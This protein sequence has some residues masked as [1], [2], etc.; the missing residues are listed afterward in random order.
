MAISLGEYDPEAKVLDVNLGEFHPLPEDQNYEQF[1]N[2]YLARKDRTIGETVWA[3]AEAIPDGMGQMVDDIDAALNNKNMVD[4]LF[5]L[6]ENEGDAKKAWESLYTASEIGLRDSYNTFNAIT[7]STINHFSDLEGEDEIKA[8]Y[9]VHQYEQDY[10]NIAREKM[11]ESVAP[12]FRDDMSVL[13]DFLDPTNLIPSTFGGKFIEKGVRKGIKG[14]TKV[15][16]VGGG[17]IIQGLGH[18]VEKTFGFPAWI[19]DKAKIKSGW[20]GIQGLGLVSAVG[21]DGLAGG[22]GTFVTGVAAL[23]FAGK[24]AKATGREIAEISRV[25]AQPSSHARFLHRVSVDETVSAA[26]RKLAARLYKMRGTKAYDVLFDGL[27]AGLSSGAIQVALEAA[28]GKSAE[29]VGA[30]TGGGIILGSPAG[31]IA[32]NRGSGKD[33]ASLNQDGTLTERSQTGVDDYLAKK[34]A[35][36][37]RKTIRA[38]KKL[39]AKSKVA[40]STLDALGELG[41]VRLHLASDADFRKLAEEAGD[42][43]ANSLP[44]M[45]QPPTKTIIL[46]EDL[47]EEGVEVAQELFLHE[48]GHAFIH[49]MLGNTPLMSRSILEQFEDPNGTEYFFRDADGKKIGSIKVND[50]AHA[51]SENYAKEIA[52]QSKDTSDKLKQD[53]DAFLLAHEIGAEQ[54]SMIFR[55]EPNA[56][57]SHNKSFR[58]MLIKAGQDALTKMGIL[59]PKTGQKSESI[60]SESM[61]KNK[62]IEKVYNNHIKLKTEHYRNRADDIETGRKIEPKAGQKSDERFQQLFGGIGVNLNLAKQFYIQDPQMYDELMAALEEAAAA[63]GNY[64]GLGKGE[65]ANR[66]F[67]K[68]RDVFAKRGAYSNQV[69]AILDFLQTAIDTRT[70]IKFGYRSA[71]GNKK[72]DY[73][74]FYERSITPIGYQISPKK[75]RNWRGKTIYPNLKVV[76]YDN[77]VIFSNIEILHNAGLLGDKSINKFMNEFA[78]RA[79]EVL[80]ADSEGRINPLGLGENEL[81]VAALGMKES[82]DSIQ[83]PKLKEFL[84]SEETKSLKNAYKSYD[85]TQLAGMQTQNRAGFGFDYRNAANNYMPALAGQGRGEPKAKFVANRDPRLTAKVAEV[86]EGTLLGK[87]YKKFVDKF[88]PV[89]VLTKDDITP[90]TLSEMRK[91]LK[92]NQVPKVNLGKEI[93]YGYPVGVRLDIDAYRYHDVWTPTIHE[94]KSETVVVNGKK[95]RRKKQS[96]IAHDPVAVIENVKFNN[97]FAESKGIGRGEKRKSSFARM[98]GNWVP[99]SVKDAV[100]LAEEALANKDGSWT[101]VGFDPERHSYFYDRE[102]HGVAMQTSDKVVQVGRAVFAKNAVKQKAEVAYGE[103]NFYAPAVKVYG[104]RDNIRSNVLGKITQGKFSPEQF[105]AKVRETKGAKEMFEDLKLDKFLEGKKSITAKEVNDFI[106]LNFPKI[107]HHSSVGGSPIYEDYIKTGGTNNYEEHVTVL[108]DPNFENGFP[109]AHWDDENVMFHWRK[110]DRY[111]DIGNGKIKPLYYLEEIQSDWHQAGRNNGY[112]TDPQVQQKL[113]DFNAYRDLR[114]KKWNEFLESVDETIMPDIENHDIINLARSYAQNNAIELAIKKFRNRLKDGSEMGFGNVLRDLFDVVRVESRESPEVR[115]FISD[116]DGSISVTYQLLKEKIEKKQLDWIGNELEKAGITQKMADD[117]FHWHRDNGQFIVPDAPFKK[118]WHGLA[119]KQAIAH[120]LAE[121]REYIAWGTGDSMA[122]LFKKDQFYDKIEVRKQVN[123]KYNIEAWTK[124]RLTQFRD[125]NAD[126]SHSNLDQKDLAKYIGAEEASLTVDKLKSAK[127]WDSKKSSSGLIDFDRSVPSVEVLDL[128]VKNQGMRNFYD[129]DLPDAA[130]VIAKQLGVRQPIKSKMASPTGKFNHPA[131]VMELP[132]K[133]P[134]V[135]NDLT[136]YMPDVKAG[137]LDQKAPR[138][139]W[140]QMQ[141]RSPKFQNFITRKGKPLFADLDEE[142]NYIPKVMYHGGTIGMQTSNPD[143]YPMGFGTIHNFGTPRDELWTPSDEKG[144]MAFFLSTDPNFSKDYQLGDMPPLQIATNVSNTF[145]FKNEDHVNKLAEKFDGDLTG[146]LGRIRKGDW[147]AI[148]DYVDEIRELGYDSF[149]IKEELNS[150]VNEIAENLGVFSPKDVK[151]IQDQKHWE[152][153]NESDLNRVGTVSG[154]F[155]GSALFA[156]EVLA[157]I[158]V[159][160]LRTQSIPTLDHGQRVGASETFQEFRDN[161]VDIANKVGLEVLE[162]KSVIGGLKDSVTGTISREASQRLFVRSK[163]DKSVN[164]FAAL[165][166]VLADELQDSVMQVRYIKRNTTKNEGRE[167]ALKINPDLAEVVTSL[168]F[169][170]KYGLE[171]GF[172]YDPKNS[173]LIFA[174]WDSKGWSSV[175]AAASAIDELGGLQGADVRP[176]TVSFPQ[177]KDYRRLLSKSRISDARR[178]GS[179]RDIDYLAET[180]RQKLKDYNEAGLFMPAVFGEKTSEKSGMKFPTI[181]YKNKVKKG[182]SLPVSS[183]DWD[184]DQWQSYFEDQKLADALMAQMASNATPEAWRLI[185]E[186]RTARTGS[187]EFPAA[188]T[189]ILSW[190]NDPQ[191]LVQFIEEARTKN[192]KM[193]DLAKDGINAA[194]VNYAATK[195]PEVVAQSFIW[196]FLSRMLDPYNQEAG[197]LRFYSD[198]KIWNALWQSI[199]GKFDMPRGI[200]Y[201]MEKVVDD[202]PSYGQKWKASAAYKKIEAQIEAFKAKKLEVKTKTAKDGLDKKIKAAKKKLKSFIDDRTKKL[203]KKLKDEFLAEAK[204]RNLNQQTGTWIDLISNM[205][206]DQNTENMISAGQNARQNANGA[207]SLLLKWNGKWD[208]VTEI[209]NSDMTGQ[210][211]REQMWSMGLEGGGIG[212]KV[213]SFVIATMADSGVVIMDRWAFVNAWLNEIKD[214]VKMRGNQL[215]SVLEDPNTDAKAKN[216]ASRLLR[217]YEKYGDNPFRYSADDIPEDR[218]N[219]YDTI[220]SKLSPMAEHSMYRTIEYYYQELAN[221][222]QQIDPKK[223]DWIDSPF[224]MHWLLWNIIKNEAVGHSSLEV[225]SD[226]LQD[227]IPQPKTDAE[228]KQYADEFINRPNYAEKNEQLPTEDFERRSRFT[229]KDG[230]P[231]EEVTERRSYRGMGGQQTGANNVYFR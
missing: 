199:D 5:G 182:E 103:G 140:E 63:E 37:D 60:I 191:K 22:I 165:A 231:T 7:Q 202:H 56:F 93:P 42:K 94:N 35:L 117:L 177:V 45:Y 1:K 207:Y 115:A 156:P 98:E 49:N 215:R 41:G 183:K 223:Y 92:E 90:P 147:M 101:Q 66:L 174:T 229:I 68:V 109:N 95:K 155:D 65:E 188:P 220:G 96:S 196:G 132:K 216:K 222:L 29:E 19:A 99:F 104:L 76:G 118:S 141:Y 133:S 136:L 26:S 106:E 61:L 67:S 113:R 39:D 212:D 102:N 214:S 70:Q 122:D 84:Q 225:L 134:D 9:A 230:R 138:L 53:K 100:T 31:A 91:A 87:D 48:F 78:Q 72:S 16:G 161:N 143:L 119:L 209:F 57:A 47:L 112:D 219:F 211:M 114:A 52:S 108:N 151:L 21:A 30:A 15:L 25:F 55:D 111:V 189:V 142:G 14:G 205:Y 80:S 24:L 43:L 181:T 59:D 206:D 73:N 204:D 201:T 23:E 69:G 110:S 10:F 38:F 170:E 77:D 128:E 44:A 2:A 121:G 32:G 74:A 123:G 184:N 58:H 153:K 135:L 171:E 175:A 51:F 64:V 218:S 12:E 160:R 145:D 194:K 163:D 105:L 75:I 116:S 62:G 227:N 217:E 158:G 124:N 50:E 213:T 169:L 120:A 97:H 46:N 36:L 107:E 167:Y 125:S 8:A 82:Y 89:D 226:V 85:V 185:N 192:P 40:L 180:A 33:T 131:W 17:K 197:W 4:S 27:V 154:K 166:G 152:G 83:E 150:N 159:A 20:R 190:L 173:E 88:K 187:A 18:T 195:T 86:T 34:A 13:A 198:P 139:I 127:P 54:F 210:Q 208:K 71:T 79:Q 176:A 28:K 221:K 179:K 157:N 172:T 224:A 149:L 6:G 130:K 148:E 81:M 178:R 168:Q 164:T 137:K 193:I 11:M 144:Q 200:Y 186:V 228:R 126:V 3:W 162:E 146:D 129:R 203:S